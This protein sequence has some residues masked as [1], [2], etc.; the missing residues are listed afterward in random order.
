MNMASEDTGIP[1]LQSIHASA[2]L[3]AIQYMNNL[4]LKQNLNTL[5]D[6]YMN[7]NGNNDIPHNAE[8]NSIRYP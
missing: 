1:I 7:I 6:R 8:N 4:C 5:E 2:S 3:N